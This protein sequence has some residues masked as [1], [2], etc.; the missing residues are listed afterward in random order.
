MPTERTRSALAKASGARP[1]DKRLWLLLCV[2]LTMTAFAANSILNRIGVAELRMDPIDFAAIRVVAGATVLWGLIAARR[3]GYATAGVQMPRRLFAAAMLATYMLG[4]SWAYISLGAG[5]GAL[6]LFGV[7]QVVTF[8][9][10]VWQGHPISPVRWIGATIA[11]LGLSV[12]LW[13]AGQT[14]VPLAG[15]L[16][17]IA[18]GIAWAIYTLLG[19]AEADALGATAGNFLLCVPLTGLAMILGGGGPMTVPG[20]VTAVVAGAV[21]SGLGYALWYRILPSIPTTVASVA[22][23]SVPVIALAAGVLLLAEP[24]TSRMLVAGAL[25]LG[26]IALSLATRRTL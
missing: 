4:F 26:G 14:T 1:V 7:L 18:A 22:Q 21:T 16:A 23:L 3:A 25:V 20:V 9:W 10:A 12:L 19:R 5:L 6:I 2:A 24:V 17:M 13:P 15:S 11:F 8:G